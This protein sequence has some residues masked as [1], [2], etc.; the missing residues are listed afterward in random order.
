M[1]DKSFLFFQWNLLGGG[2]TKCCGIFPVCGSMISYA[3]DIVGS[4][5]FVIVDDYDWMTVC[6]MKA[7]A[8]ILGCLML[9]D[10][11]TI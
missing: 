9:I 8:S 1:F 7:S 3:E 4:D 5:H 6:S 11:E 10:G 2:S